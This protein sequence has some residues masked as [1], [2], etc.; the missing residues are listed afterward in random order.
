MPTRQNNNILQ[1]FIL[2]DIVETDE[3]VETFSMD[4]IYLTS[5]TCQTDYLASDRIIQYDLENRDSCY[6]LSQDNC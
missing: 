4:G 6:Y 1:M 5:R 3:I 2:G